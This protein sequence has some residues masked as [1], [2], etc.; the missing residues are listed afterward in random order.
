MAI[1]PPPF[2]PNLAPPQ[3]PAGWRAEWSPEHNTWYYLNLT[4]NASQ[5]NFPVE[6][7]Q[8]PYGS[9]PPPQ[10]YPPY[11]QQQSDTP[12]S[13]QIGTVPEPTGEVGPDGERGLG[14]IAAGGLLGV[15]GGLVARAIFKHEEEEGKIQKPHFS[16]WNNG[17]NSSN[18]QPDSNGPSSWLSKL[19]G[20]GNKPDFTIP[21]AAAAGGG[22]FGSL[23][24]HIPGFSASGQQPAAQMY[25]SPSWHTGNNPK[26]HIHCAAWSDQD[27]THLIRRMVTPSQSIDFNTDDLGDHLGD[28][29]PG[30]P[31][32]FSIVYSYGPRPWELVSTSSGRGKFSLL[33]HEPLSKDRMSFIQAPNSRVMGVVWG[34]GNA[35]EKGTVEKLKEI[36]TTGEFQATNEWAGFDDMWGPGKVAV[37]YY[38]TQ[39]GEVKFAAAREGRTCRLP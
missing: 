12:Q 28:P 33:P 2:P 22:L 29:W 24:S 1:A 21:A 32:Q 18:N 16:F 14:K 34:R 36:E 11:Q 23:A 9:P 15:A 27:V 13:Q 31:K 5:W 26:L 30:A 25:A 19:S 6:Q 8:T 7:V 3:V 39:N 38:R 17:D 20:G 37:A 35:L 4:T 10:Q